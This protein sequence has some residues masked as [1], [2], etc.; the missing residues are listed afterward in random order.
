MRSLLR[1]TSR[2][3][4]EHYV[5]KWFAVPIL[6]MAS[7]IFIVGLLVVAT[8]AVE[9]LTLVGLFVAFSFAVVAAGLV[10]DRIVSRGTGGRL[11]GTK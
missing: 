9:M 1:R 3:L 8:T 7:I 5:F 11:L 10:L 2:Y 4:D 6:F